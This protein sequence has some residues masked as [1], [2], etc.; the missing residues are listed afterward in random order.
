MENRPEYVSTNYQ[1]R[2]ICVNTV[3]T[4][5]HTNTM[6]KVTRDPLLYS[7][8]VS[9]CRALTLRSKL[10]MGFIVLHCIYLLEKKIISWW[11]RMHIHIHIVVCTIC[12]RQEQKVTF[13]N[14]TKTARQC[15]RLKVF[16]LILFPPVVWSPFSTESLHFIRGRVTYW[17][18]MFLWQLWLGLFVSGLHLPPF[19]SSMWQN[20]RILQ[21][22]GPLLKCLCMYVVGEAFWPFP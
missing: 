20:W 18:W 2:P 13:I 17:A 16:F 8:V 4:C 6:L 1:H 22:K 15:I 14:Y 9:V 12:D 5:T 11:N 10:Q 7:T 3:H 19:I 21:E